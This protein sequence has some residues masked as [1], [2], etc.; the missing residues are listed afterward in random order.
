MDQIAHAG[1][2]AP[3]G[4]LSARARGPFRAVDPRLLHYTR[5]TRR[6]LV[7]T[8]ALGGVTAGLVLAQAWLI[9]T[10]VSDV[11]VH[12]WPLERVVTLVVLLALAVLARAA[13]AWLGERMADRAS[14]AAKSE[15]RATLATRIAALGPAA[16]DSQPAGRLV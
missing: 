5:G 8:V 14:A 12:H 4:Q 16:V 7:L 9:A 2:D 15:L 6:F 11:V 1:S 10:T 3:P 13:V